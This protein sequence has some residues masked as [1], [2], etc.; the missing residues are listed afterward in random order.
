MIE[1]C[2]LG[3]CSKCAL[4]SSDRSQDTGLGGPKK[5]FRHPAR[6]YPPHAERPKRVFRPRSPQRSPPCRG[7]PTP[8]DARLRAD[9]HGRFAANSTPSAPPQ[10]GG[11]R[12]PWTGPTPDPAPVEQNPLC[13]QSMQQ[14]GTGRDPPVRLLRRRPPWPGRRPSSPDPD[15]GLRERRMPP[16]QGINAAEAFR[17]RS[18]LCGARAGITAGEVL[19]FDQ[20][21]GPCRRTEM[22]SA[23][24]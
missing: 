21:T 24:A 19:R 6:R 8:L 15:S 1:C 5:V 14:R 9:S 12:P 22:R 10:A 4:R 20:D 2:S 11:R 13:T 23:N 3:L 7:A 16:L 17:Q 18:A